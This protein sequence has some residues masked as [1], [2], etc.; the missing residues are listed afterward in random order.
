MLENPGSIE[1]E[2]S[3]FHALSGIHAGL[4]MLVCCSTAVPPNKWLQQHMI[5]LILYHT[6]QHK[7]PVRWKQLVRL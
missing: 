7:L 4:V 6:C 3:S 1:R 2:Q 5:L